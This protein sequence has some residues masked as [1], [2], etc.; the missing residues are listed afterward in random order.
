MLI[1]I[2]MHMSIEL[3]SQRTYCLKLAPPKM[4]NILRFSTLKVFMQF[5]QNST[6]F[7]DWSDE[8]VHQGEKSFCS[9]LS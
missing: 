3:V 2:Y 5:C 9:S 7:V 1:H 6:D 8:S 4:T